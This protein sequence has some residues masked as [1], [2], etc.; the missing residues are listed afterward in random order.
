[1][2]TM[3]PAPALGTWIASKVASLDERFRAA[4]RPRATYGFLDRV[5]RFPAHGCDRKRLVRAGAGF[6]RHSFKIPGPTLRLLAST[7]TSWAPV[8]A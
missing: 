1:M 6:A 8:P 4:T 3:D 2:G 5:P 7:G